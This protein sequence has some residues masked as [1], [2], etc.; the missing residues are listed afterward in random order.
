M[1]ILFQPE[2]VEALSNVAQSTTDSWKGNDRFYSND[3]GTTNITSTYA[4]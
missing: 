3:T 4:C 1:S 2:R